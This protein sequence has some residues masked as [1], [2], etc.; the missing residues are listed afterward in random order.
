MLKFSSPQNLYCYLKTFN[1]RVIIAFILLLIFISACDRKTE[2]NDTTPEE[3]QFTVNPALLGNKIIHDNNLFEFYVPKLLSV[4]EYDFAGI[5]QQLNSV[6]TGGIVLT[7]L[8]LLTD[9]SKENSLTVSRVTL[10]EDFLSDPIDY[11]SEVISN[12]DLFN[13]ASK[14]K[15][16]K[17]GIVISQLITRHDNHIII[18]IIFEPKD[19]CLIQLD[20]IFNEENYKQEV[21]SIESSIGSIKIL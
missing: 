5:E 11:Y 1:R 14:A 18:K 8:Y 15:F 21:R 2:L 17:D 9:S 6:L 19:N 13:S 7:L 10:I 20:Y 3:I 16:L 4:Q 12:T